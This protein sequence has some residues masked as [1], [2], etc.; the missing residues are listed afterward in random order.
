MGIHLVLN[1]SPHTKGLWSELYL[2]NGVPLCAIAIVILAPRIDDRFGHYFIAAAITL[3]L[4]GSLISSF[5]T[6]YII[7]IPTQF[8]SNIAY[9]LFYPFII[10]TLPKII[11]PNHTFTRL[12]IFE[13]LIISLGFTTLG[14]TLALSQ[15]LPHNGGGI[16]QNFFSIAFPVADLILLSL[17]FTLV[18]VRGIS[19]RGSMLTLG[20]VIFSVSDYLFLGMHAE[21]TYTFGSLVDDGWLIGLLIIA[22]SLWQRN[23]EFVEN[24]NASPVLITLSVFLSATI[25]ALIAL[26]PGYFPSYV[27]LPTISY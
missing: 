8:F 13:A 21:G 15:V 3:W 11:S 14:T 16:R 26:R 1:L 20:V 9:L 2:Y 10:L 25:L 27:L 7:A 23:S 5:S 19:R 17:T 4:I 6:Y 18:L 24:K 12:E 22:M